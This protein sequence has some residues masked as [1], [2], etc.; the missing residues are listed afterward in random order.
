MKYVIYIFII[1]CVLTGAASCDK[2]T[3]VHKEFIKDGETVYAV[4]PDSVAFVSGKQRLKMR[5]WMVN[6][7]NVKDMVVT[8]NN[9][10]DSL[11]VPASFKSGRD[12]MEVLITGLEEKSYAFNIYSI[13]NFK[14]RSLTYTQFGAAYG[15]L[16][17]ST[18]VNRRIRQVSLTEASAGIEWFAGGEGM[19]YNEIK[20]ISKFSGLDTVLRTPSGSFSISFDAKAGSAF[21]YR[22]LFIPQA[23]SI[24][25]F[26]TNWD[27][28]QLPDT[29]L[30]NRSLWKV[31]AVSDERASDGGG[32]NT[33][34][35]GNLDSYWHSQ[36]DPHAPLPHW[37]IIDMV[38]DKNIS[39]FEIYRRKGN[40][41]A[42]TAQ[43]YVGD[44]PDP[45]G[46]WTLAGQGVFASGDK[47]SINNTNQ[48]KG[49]YMK[50]QFPDSN[51]PPFTAIAEVYVYGK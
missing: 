46:T 12:S 15:S 47:L 14:N 44:S 13:D 27:D 21:Q 32:M 30:F 35:D 41:D 16:Y 18:L 20:Y 43:V 38:S 33:L 45:L 17:A 28:G 8:W 48:A 1:C 37:A 9:G 22:S 6:G 29:Y 5:L 23:A 19:I 40:T 49:R 42:K 34:I 50:I 25:T 31:L 11:V 39:Y 10:A 26:Y 3:D 51:R 7:V 2:F 4:K 24:D 36:Y